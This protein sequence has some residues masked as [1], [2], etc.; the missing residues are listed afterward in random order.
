SGGGTLDLNGIS[1]FNPGEFVTI[2]GNGVGNTGAIINSGADQNNG[3]RYVSLAGDATIGSSSP[4][5]WDIRGP[6]GASSFSGGLF[7]NGF[8]LTKVGVGKNSLVDS[9]ITNAGSIVLSNGTLGITRTVVDG[10]GTI[11]AFGTNILQLEN[12]STGYVT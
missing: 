5:R 10:P 12:S 3:L 1:L 6:G 8:T 7:L 2:S 4:G 9:T 11:S